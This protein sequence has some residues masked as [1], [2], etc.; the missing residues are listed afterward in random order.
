MDDSADDS[1]DDSSDD[2]SS[3]GVS[4]S[5][6]FRAPHRGIPGSHHETG[7]DWYR[8]NKWPP[9]DVADSWTPISAT[10]NGFLSNIGR[11][12]TCRSQSSRI[13]A[14]TG[15]GPG[16]RNWNSLESLL[17]PTLIGA[18]VTDEPRNSRI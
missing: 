13:R 10:K 2:S 6:A 11:P 18:N 8:G 3:V 12:F 16:N 7:E 14:A 4:I 15:P 1:A 9:T 17:D 5:A